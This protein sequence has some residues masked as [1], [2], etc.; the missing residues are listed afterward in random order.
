MTV[1]IRRSRLVRALI[2]TLG[3]GFAAVATAQNPADQANPFGAGDPFG[4]SAPAVVAPTNSAS[5]ESEPMSPLLYAITKQDFSQPANRILA[6]ET[7]FLLKRADQANI[8]LADLKQPLTGR[9]AFDFVFAVTSSRILWLQSQ[10]ELSPEMTTWLS[11]TMANAM[12]YSV[13]EESTNQSL[14]DLLEGNPSEQASA[15]D[16]LLAQGLAAATPLLRR[17]QEQIDKSDVQSVQLRR[18]IQVI[19]SGPTDWDATLRSVVGH[20]SEIESAAILALAAR[21]RSALNQAAV[22]EWMARKPGSLPEPSLAE[23]IGHWRTVFKSQHGF[24]PVQSE[25]TSRWL[26]QLNEAE[27]RQWDVLQSPRTQFERATPTTWLWDT[28]LKNLTPQLVEPLDQASR[29]Q[30]LVATA[31]LR[32]DAEN[33]TALRNYVAT[34]FQRAKLLNGIDSPLPQTAVEVAAQYLSAPQM[35]EMLSQ[36]MEQGQW[37]VAQSLL[38]ALR[39]VGNAQLMETTAGR[40]SPIATAL[41]APDQRVRTAAVQ[42]ILAWKPEQSFAGTSYFNQG[43]QEVLSTPNGTFAVIASMNPYHAA[44]LES[45][46]RG[47]GWEA[48]VAPTAGRLI[49]ELN[50]YPASFFIVTDSLGEV[51]YLEVID[52]VRSTPKGR[53]MPILLLVRSENLN[54]ARTMLQVDRNDPYIMV[55]E[56]SENGRDLLPWIEKLSSWKEV[57]RQMPSSVARDHAS[58]ALA[59]LSVWLNSDRAR[60]L[61]DFSVFAGSARGLIGSVGSADAVIVDV[62]SSYGDPETQLYL[63]GLAAEGA[64]TSEIRSAAAKGFRASVE[65]FGTLMTSKQIE[66]QYDRQNQSRNEAPF[67]QAI[68]N[69]ILD[70]LEARTRK[71]PFSE[72]PPIPGM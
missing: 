47:A 3:G 32:V 2:S 14:R 22:I 27:A 31:W 44:Y 64:V 17:I 19:Q 69:S 6:A 49:A 71:V 59:Q 68:L 33:E 30:A 9:E 37:L 52:Q 55:A 25:L 63:A 48:S 58:Q 66:A 56:F 11:T 72:L 24:D 7:L 34:Q 42:T 10:P 28:E 39:T 70:T 41:K 57:T 45:L 15:R 43:L 65:R 5:Q 38:E 29:N 4:G 35:C 40:L 51:P 23:V 26:E 36:A 50:M 53:T 60:R 62:L 54:N 13:S 16:K 12:Q 67:T 18:L 46:V 1:T 21:S 20:E 61:L 8:V